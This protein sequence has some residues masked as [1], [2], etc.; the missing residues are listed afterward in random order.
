MNVHALNSLLPPAGEK[1][2]EWLARAIAVAAAAHAGQLDKNGKAYFLHPMR[3]MQRCEQHGVDAQIVAVLHDVVEDTWVSLDDLVALGFSSPVVEAVDAISQRTGRETYFEYIERCARNRT[4]ALVKLADLH[5]NSDP[6]RRF[7]RHHES[8][9]E[10]YAK[11][12]DIIN[13]RL[14]L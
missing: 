7:S 9:L 14:G 1:P 13:T 11:A 6:A 8:L 5:D 12:R 4:A 10:R 3:V 2:A